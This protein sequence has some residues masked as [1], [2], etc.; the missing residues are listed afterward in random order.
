MVSFKFSRKWIIIPIVLIILW[1]FNK[2]NKENFYNILP[3]E[4][5]DSRYYNINQD[6]FDYKH[7][8]RVGDIFGTDMNC[9]NV[10][11]PD[12]LNWIKNNDPHTLHQYVYLYDPSVNIKNPIHTP[13]ILKMLLRNLPEQHKYIPIIRKCMYKQVRIS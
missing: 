2:K 3:T 10:N 9:N 4:L 6:P 7:H 5:I 13:R 8:L 1:Y 12:L 11:I